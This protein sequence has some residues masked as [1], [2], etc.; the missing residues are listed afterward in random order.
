[1]NDFSD[2]VSISNLVIQPGDGGNSIR[3]GQRSFSWVTKN[4]DV[5][6]NVQILAD[7]NWTCTTLSGRVHQGRMSAYFVY[8]KPMEEK[9]GNINEKYTEFETYVRE[10]MIKYPPHKD[11]WTNWIGTD[12]LGRWDNIFSADFFTSMYY[13]VSVDQKTNTNRSS[14]SSRK[15]AEKELF[16]DDS[17]DFSD[18]VSISNL[19]IQPGDSIRLGPRSFSWVTKNRDV[20]VTVQMSKDGNWTCTTNSGR[21]HQGGMGAYFVDR[22]PMEVKEGNI[23]E[24][25]TEFETYVRERMIKYPPHKD[26]WTNWIEADTL[27]RW[28]SI[29]SADFFTSMYYF[30]SVDQKTN[31][32]SV[33]SRKLAEKELFGDDSE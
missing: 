12:T 33:S 18:F 2:F 31:R 21:V 7:G 19:F 32:S 11:Y 10:R 29:F 3:L 17:T 27:G 6:V 24:K 5:K 4:R 15:L 16:S 9:E 23:D 13:F 20:E 22:K 14:V 25:Y 26:Y 1:M 30:V 8:R 28:N